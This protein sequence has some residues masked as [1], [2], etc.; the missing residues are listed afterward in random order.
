MCGHMDQT[1]P[2]H[3]IISDP[4]VMLMHH[5]ATIK[6]PTYGTI[7]KPPHSPSQQQ[8]S[9]SRRWQCRS[10]AGR[11][12]S[13]SRVTRIIILTL[14]SFSD[15]FNEFVSEP[16]VRVS[17]SQIKKFDSS[18]AHLSAGHYRIRH[19]TLRRLR[20][21]R[22]EKRPCSWCWDDSQKSKNQTQ[23]VKSIGNRSL[24]LHFLSHWFPRF[25]PNRTAADIQEKVIPPF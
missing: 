9:P 25:G 2:A 4:S 18:W 14:I 1:E 20:R 17:S 21:R 6:I 7:S 23:S 13:A 5:E 3:S 10:S 16:N 8:P 19:A 22:R 11:V 15:P 24:K 12:S